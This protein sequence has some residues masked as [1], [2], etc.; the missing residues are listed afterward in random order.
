MKESE[1]IT[2]VRALQKYLDEQ[3]KGVETHLEA[4]DGHLQAID[5]R[6]VQLELKLGQRIDDLEERMDQRFDDVHSAIK[7]LDR[8]VFQLERGS[9]RVKEPAE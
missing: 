7:G 4:I 2:E 9:P 1:E 6:F 3:F 8:R 5:Q